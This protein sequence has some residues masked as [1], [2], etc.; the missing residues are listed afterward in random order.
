MITYKNARR[1]E[2]AGFA[3]VA[4]EGRARENLV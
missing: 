4:G 1:P 3:L 2:P